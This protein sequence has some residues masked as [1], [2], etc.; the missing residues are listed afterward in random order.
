MPSIERAK[1]IAQS[2]LLFTFLIALG[3]LVGLAAGFSAGVRLHSQQA[4]PTANCVTGYMPREINGT[5][6]LVPVQICR[7]PAAP[8]TKNFPQIV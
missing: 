5:S 2:I 3:L 8:R 7:Q 4:R 1:R 6:V